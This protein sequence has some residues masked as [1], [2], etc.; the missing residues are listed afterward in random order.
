[1][2]QTIID[3]LLIDKIG[4]NKVCNNC[5]VQNGM[6]TTPLT[7]YLISDNLTLPNERIMFIGKVA[8]GDSFG[9]YVAD[10]LEDVTSFGKDYLENNS[11]A[12]YSYTKEIVETYYGDFE[13]ALKYI[14]F[15]NMVKC[16]NETMNDTTPWDAKVNC[17]DKNKF[18]W[19]EVEII[20]PKKII[21]YTH[22][23]YDTF[24]EKF[25]PTD[26]Y[27]INDITDINHRVNIGNKT[28]LYWHREFLDKNNNI[29]CSFLRVSHPMMKNRVDFIDSILTWLKQG[30]KN[31]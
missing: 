27:S 31:N 8:R 24:I 23:Y 5:K 11:W 4:I 19:K 20:K 13:R 25:R 2:K 26:C 9:E 28:S 30:E 14:S 29:V 17:I 21:F 1:M 10:N 12:Y 18:I 22:N 15:S 16:N 3:Q 6:C 7:P